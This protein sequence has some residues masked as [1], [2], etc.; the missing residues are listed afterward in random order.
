[1]KIAD[2]CF[3]YGEK[4]IL[5]H[6]SLELP[7][8][9]ITALAG[10]SG[11][12]K[13]TLLRILGGLETPR[14]GMLD[15]PPA[16]RTAFLFQENRLL[17]GFPA[18]EQIRLV[19]PRGDDPLPWLEA[20][21]LSEE[22]KTLPGELSG[23]MQRRVAL[24]RCLANGRDTDLFLLDEPFTGIDPGP[25]RSLM[26]FLRSLNVPA[27]CTAHDAETLE[28]AD[29]IIRLEGPPFAPTATPQSPHSVPPGT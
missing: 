2:I 16:H 14:S 13:T 25:A 3:S 7:D 27:L 12:G 1:M 5:N 18:A 10:P 11:C 24:A 17:P 15:T 22:A 26:D 21:G 29:R 9:G 6:F 19:L 28:L 8:E 20:V 23:G 4:I